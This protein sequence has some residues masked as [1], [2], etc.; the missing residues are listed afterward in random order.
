M[1]TSVQRIFYRSLI[2]RAIL[3]REGTPFEQ[4]F[5][6]LAQR[7]WGGDFEPVRA[8]GRM[9]DLKCDG[10]RRSTG[11]IFQCY[12]PRNLNNSSL[13]SKIGD[14]FIGAKAVWGD[15]M[16]GWTL[17]INDREGLHA[18]AKS[19]TE[20]LREDN[21]AIDIQT[22]GP[23]E[24]EQLALS[25]PADQLGDLCGMH[26]SPAEARTLRISFEAIDT[27]VGQLSGSNPMPSVDGLSVPAATKAEHNDLD[28]EIREFLRRGE[29][30][31]NRVAQYFRE[32]GRVESGE[33]ISTKFGE[34]YRCMKALGHD[35]NRIFFEF[36]ELCGGLRRPEAE[37]VAVLAVITYFFNSC[38]IFENAPSAVV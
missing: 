27:V 6:E 25:L 24:L 8:Q 11:T 28:G 35:A 3:E 10:H 36:I 31:T 1:L 16:K 19:K 15:R 7:A 21:E 18:E 5:C 29:Q 26:L 33:K 14:D 30:W 23:I 17:V 20:T 32:T 37:R 9:G 4:W 34:D 38:D 13:T 2:S 12:A 22:M